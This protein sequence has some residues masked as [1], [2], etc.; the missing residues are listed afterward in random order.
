MAKT[1]VFLADDHAVLRAGLRL[2]INTQ[3]DLEVVGESG[4][5]A[6]TLAGL[7]VHKP[8]IVTLDLSMPGG[9]GIQL[10]EAILRQHSKTRVLVLTMHDDPAYLRMALA[11]G[12]S[13]YVVKKSADSEL[14]S[15]LRAIASG[16]TYTLVS[17]ADAPLAH[18]SH[19]RPPADPR[20]DQL[21]EREREVFLLIAQGHTSQAVAD[22][23]FVSVKTIESYRARLMTKL[24]LKNRAELTQFAIEMGLLGPP[25]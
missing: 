10:I 23:L 8:D 16:R 25:S 19:G 17:L 9:S 15:A 20:L 14:I 13:G 2:L 24:G 21:S 11:A 12:A 3:P 22:R 5:R 7:D 6:S 1:R 18:A 4:D